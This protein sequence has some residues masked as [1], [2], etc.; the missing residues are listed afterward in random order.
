MHLSNFLVFF[1]AFFAVLHR[2]I[3]QP[4]KRKTIKVMAIGCL[5]WEQ[6]WNFII[7]VIMAKPSLAFRWLR[8]KVMLLRSIC[9]GNVSLPGVAQS[10]ITL[11]Q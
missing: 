1:S 8:V 10:K 7:E 9:L 6:L 11:R 5:A 3:A 4:I 2:L